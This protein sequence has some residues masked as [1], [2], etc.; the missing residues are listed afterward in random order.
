MSDE[1]LLLP[2]L[3]STLG[4]FESPLLNMDKLHMPSHHTFISILLATNLASVL[5]PLMYLFLVLIQC[6]GTA[7]FLVT[8]VA[9]ERLLLSMNYSMPSQIPLILESFPTNSASTFSLPSL[10]H[11]Y[12]LYPV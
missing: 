2:D 1:T 3:Q 10:G 12:H 11:P 6:P 5:Q 7:T 9:L 8:H 4:T